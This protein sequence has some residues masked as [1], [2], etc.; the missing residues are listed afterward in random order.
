VRACLERQ[1]HYLDITGEIDVFEHAQTLSSAARTAGVVICP[2]VGFD[3]IPTD[4][5]AR[6]LVE[7]LPDATHLALGFET[8]A[9]M[10]PGTAKTSVEGLARG[11]RVRRDGKIVRVPMGVRTRQ[12]DFGQGPRTCVFI[13]SDALFRG[14][15]RFGERPANRAR[16]P[17]LNT[18][19]WAQGHSVLP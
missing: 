19:L 16:A 7:A 1:V 8:V 6:A 5:L 9:A 2:G 4:C 3:V 17:R 10:F 11:G 13:G 14:V 12:I 15:R 18:L